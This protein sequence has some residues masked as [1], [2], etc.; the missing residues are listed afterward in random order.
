MRLKKYRNIAL[1]VILPLFILSMAT[2]IILLNEFLPTLENYQSYWKFRRWISKNLLGKYHP[3]SK[4]IFQSDEFVLNPT[5]FPKKLPTFKFG[6]IFISEDPLVYQSKLRQQ[7]KNNFA[8][9]K[10]PKGEFN[11]QIHTTDNKEGYVEQK[12]SYQTQSGIRIP[13]YLLIPSD[14][15]PP[16]PAVLIS[17]GCGHGKVGVVGK[18]KDIHNSIGVELV[19]AGILVLAP[20]RR[21]FGELQP[22]AEYISPSCGSGFPDG[23]ILLEKDAELNFNTSLRALDVYDMMLAAEYLSRRKDVSKVG[24]AGL[25]GGGVVASYVAGLSQNIQC[26]VLSNSFSFQQELVDSID[27]ESVESFKEKLFSYPNTPSEMLSNLQNFPTNNSFSNKIK[28]M[29]LTPLALLPKTPLLI[30]FGKHDKVGYSTIGPEVIQYIR[31]IYACFDAE[32][33]IDVSID[34]GGHEFIVDPIVKY[35]KTQLY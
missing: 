15:P 18:I 31:D 2:N 21:G 26:V 12:V 28:N 25:S 16:W 8:L 33:L 9:F 6:D 7:I 11:F 34:N 4:I 27:I 35:F 17:H 29:Y 30:Q 5:S 24:L 10:I 1:T 32:F 14:K 19:N 20:D 23:R 13:A 22:I 3:D